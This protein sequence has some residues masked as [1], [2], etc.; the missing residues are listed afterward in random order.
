MQG[1]VRGERDF[2]IFSA[3]LD[4]TLRLWDPET[5]ACLRVFRGGP[6][7]ISACT[8]FEAWNTLVSGHDCGAVALWNVATGTPHV[9]RRHGNTVSCMQ[10]GVVGVRGSSLCDRCDLFGVHQCWSGPTL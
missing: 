10:L 2:R 3:S 4:G 7:D 1:Q 6:S 9:L 8:F 5:L